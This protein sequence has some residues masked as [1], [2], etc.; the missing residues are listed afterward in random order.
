MNVFDIIVYISLA[1]AVFNG[2]RRGFLLQMLSLFAVVASMYF[3]VQYGPELES[4]LGID[5]GVSGVVGFI[6]IFLAALLLISVGAYLLRA[7]FRFAGLGVVDILLGVAFSL[8]KVMLI[9]SVL[10]SWFTSVNKNY[11]WASKSTIESSRWFA[12]VKGI[13]DKLT[14]YFEDIADKLLD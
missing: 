3:A 11:E 14:P 5:V 12:P 7:V 4:I 10:F 6:V 2:W 8:V 13:T 1:W 9:V